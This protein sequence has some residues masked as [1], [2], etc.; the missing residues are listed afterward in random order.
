MIHTSTSLFT[1]RP[2]GASVLALKANLDC[3]SLLAVA[4]SRGITCREV[5]GKDLETEKALLTRMAKVL[6][7]ADFYGYNLDAFDE[8]MRDREFTPR[9][10]TL[11][12]VHRADLV[13]R[14]GTRG[15]KKLWSD[16]LGDVDAGK[17]KSGYA[18]FDDPFIYPPFWLVSV[19]Q[20]LR[21]MQQWQELAGRE[22]A[23][24]EDDP[25]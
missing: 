15:G 6:C 12:I 17:E 1:D 19:Y 18:G 10:P 9:G 16:L 20:D 4:A 25:R 7:F 14:R 3:S 5:D 21:S 22:L 24:V 13:Q 2:D 23:I 8:C 11:L